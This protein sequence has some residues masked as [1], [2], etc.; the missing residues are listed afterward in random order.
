MRGYLVSRLAARGRSA[1]GVCGAAVAALGWGG[2]RS[3]EVRSG[4]VRRAV[5]VV[6]LLT[7][8]SEAP[9]S[10][11]PC[12]QRDTSTPADSSRCLKATCA[13]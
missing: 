8:Y 3:V 11:S 6:R 1:A 2:G 4:F 9:C 7:H 13:A 12:Y 5:V 10:G